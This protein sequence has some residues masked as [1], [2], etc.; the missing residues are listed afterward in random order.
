MVDQELSGRKVLATMMKIDADTIAEHN[1]TIPLISDK[2]LRWKVADDR[3]GRQIRKRRLAGP[4]RYRCAYRPRRR[5]KLFGGR[6]H[7]M[8]LRSVRHA[9]FTEFDVRGTTYT[10][11]ASDE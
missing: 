4:S 1:G 8:S 9:S 3:C 10:I 6:R 11:G 2:R 5:G 7:G